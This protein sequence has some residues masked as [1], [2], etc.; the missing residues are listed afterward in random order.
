MK[1]IDS[2]GLLASL[3]ERAT[4]LSPDRE[5]SVTFD[6]EGRWLFYYRR[7]RTY[8]RSL[9]SEVHLRFR[10]GG[11][12][13][14]RL[15][16]ERGA[17]ISREVHELAA[18]VLPDT[19]G[20]VK[21]RLESEILPWTVPRLEAE[22]RRFHEVYRPI[23]ILPPDQYLS[24][25]LQ[26][27]EGCTWNACTFCNFYMDRPFAVKSPA[28]FARHASGVSE[29]LGRGL[30]L[31]R[32]VFLG[33][34]NALALSVRRLEPLLELARRQFPGERLY[35]FVDVYSGERRRTRDWR[36]LAD[37]GLERI[38]VGMETGCDELLRFVNKPGSTR[39]LTE[40]VRQLKAGG[41]RVSLIVM[42]GLGG[43][44]YRRRH[45]GATLEALRQLPL[46]SRDLIYLSPFREHPETPY[47]GLREAGGLTAMSEPDI[48]IE[49]QL[50]AATLR[51]YGL[52]VGR[53]DIREF[54]Y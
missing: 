44:E 15:S 48:E 20:E 40:F 19:H 6:R 7:G 46:D 33:D 50:M 5:H 3:T 41:L 10:A 54:V 36:R 18:E 38:Y 43:R 13:R 30:S 39:E 27:T 52:R 31:R 51:G 23:P 12:R 8:K 21:R 4:V 28:E 25:V 35:G 2:S 49:L 34:G 17:A 11:R 53:Y 37:L 42:V 45:R 32:G 26:A 24:I 14:R 1:Q 16:P 22:A 29:L 9:A 47:R